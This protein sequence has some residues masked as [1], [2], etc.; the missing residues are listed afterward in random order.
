MEALLFHFGKTSWNY[1]MRI[2]T[3]PKEPIRI[4]TF[5]N[6]IENIV[7]AILYTH[8]ISQVMTPIADPYRVLYI[9]V[10]SSCYT[11]T[12]WPFLYWLLWI[13]SSYQISK[14]IIIGFLMLWF[15]VQGYW[16]RISNKSK[17]YRFLL[18]ILGPLSKW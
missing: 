15:Q 16:N 2:Q 13:G 18:V 8:G 12:V 3:Y 14:T 11:C 5:Q 9:M 6:P 1:K 17:Q 7:P 4:L 10:L